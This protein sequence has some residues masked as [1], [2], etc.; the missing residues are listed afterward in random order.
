[1]VAAVGGI[2]SNGQSVKWGRPAKDPQQAHFEASKAMKEQAQ[3]AQVSEHFWLPG[4]R[5]HDRTSNTEW[6]VLP[7]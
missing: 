5:K 6:C 3:P 4:R 2:G 7:L 1:M